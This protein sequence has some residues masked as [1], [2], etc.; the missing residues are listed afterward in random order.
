MDSRTTCATVRVVR[1]C[2]VRPTVR[3]CE[4]SHPSHRRTHHRTLAPC[5]VRTF[6]RQYVPVP[7]GSGVATTSRIPIDI[8][9]FPW[10][11]PLV[12]DYAFDH[13]KVADFFAGDPRDARAWREAITQARAHGRSREAIADIVH[14]QQRGRGAPAEALEASAR[15]RDPQTV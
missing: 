15:L 9:R 13:A 12:A 1:R 8:R 10:I 4:P 7:P 6:L 11:R 3:K 5:T 2:D 14:A